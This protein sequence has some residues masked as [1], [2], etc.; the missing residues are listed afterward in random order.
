[1]NTSFRKEV[2]RE[3]EAEEFPLQETGC[4]HWLTGT[5]PGSDGSQSEAPM[6]L[7]GGALC[8]HFPMEATVPV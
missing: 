7:V 3:N 8:V 6:W 2:K 4:F 5:C 1:M